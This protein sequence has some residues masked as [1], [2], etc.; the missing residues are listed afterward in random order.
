MS[1]PQENVQKKINNI[2][3]PTRIFDLVNWAAF[4]HLE[5]SKKTFSLQYGPYYMEVKYGLQT[6]TTHIL[7]GIIP[8]AAYALAW[9]YYIS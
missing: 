9:G 6:L 2:C 1:R 8:T 4:W 7:Y 3:R 5:S